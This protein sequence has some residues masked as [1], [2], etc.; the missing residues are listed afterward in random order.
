L[1]ILYANGKMDSGTVFI[2]H[3]ITT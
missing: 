2:E 3:D 1:Q